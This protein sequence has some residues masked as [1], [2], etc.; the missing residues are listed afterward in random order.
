MGSSY[1]IVLDTSSSNKTV[2]GNLQTVAG[3]TG[4]KSWDDLANSA[5]LSCVAPP[6]PLCNV[7]VP[8][9][10][11]VRVAAGGNASALYS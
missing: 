8:Q 1:A 10:S 9:L 3:P 6:P 7:T 4:K 11:C 5:K 2:V